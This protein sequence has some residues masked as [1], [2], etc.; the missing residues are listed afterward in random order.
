MGSDV[1]PPRRSHVALAIG[2]AK[3]QGPTIDSFDRIRPEWVRSFKRGPAHI[4][5]L[6][7]P[8]RNSLKLQ[9]TDNIFSEP[10][11][12]RPSQR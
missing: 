10:H 5:N 11:H 3:R 9:Q 6:W 2:K 8:R 1:R 4:Q 7:K 12:A